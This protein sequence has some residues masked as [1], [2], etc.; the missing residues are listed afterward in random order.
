MK[1]SNSDQNLPPDI[2]ILIILKE[3]LRL[4]VSHKDS[5]AG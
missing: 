4:Y 5:L 3:E 1:Y 2:I